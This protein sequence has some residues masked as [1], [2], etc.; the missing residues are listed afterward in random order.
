M[1]YIASTIAEVRGPT[2]SEKLWLVG[3]T[4]ATLLGLVI[5][6][7]CIMRFRRWLKDDIVISGSDNA[8][9]LDEIKQMHLKGLISNEEYA[10]MKE[11]YVKRM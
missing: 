6:G 2:D 11:A 3:L 8:L 1:N 5:I 4:V 9:G 7:Y 10:R